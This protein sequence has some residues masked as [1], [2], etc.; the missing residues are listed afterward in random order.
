MDLL[1]KC[2]K[3]GMVHCTLNA[4]KPE[5]ICNCDK[6]H[7]GFLKSM[8]KFHRLGGFD[9]SN[10]RAKI[11]ESIK[12]NE[13]YRCVD[14]CPTHAIYPSIEAGGKFVPELNL[15]LCIGCGVCSSNCSVNR[16]L[17]EKVENKIPEPSMID[18][19]KRYGMERTKNQMT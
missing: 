13:C 11:E 5:F 7:C 15:D 1:I 19:Y 2:E 9:L 3:K 4:Q 14:L 10:F 16:I 8:T 6:E 17:L 18:A 12:C